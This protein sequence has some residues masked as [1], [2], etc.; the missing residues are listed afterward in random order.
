MKST[1]ATS[2]HGQAER[3]RRMAKGRISRGHS[4]GGSSRRPRMA[5]ASRRIPASMSGAP[6]KTLSM[7]GIARCQ[8]SLSHFPSEMGLPAGSV[9]LASWTCPTTIRTSPA[10]AVGQRRMRQMDLWEYLVV[11]TELDGKPMTVSFPNATPTGGNNY[12]MPDR[13]QNLPILSC[14]GDKTAGPLLHPAGPLG[15][16]GERPPL[17]CSERP[18]GRVCSIVCPRQPGC[19]P[20][21]SAG[22]PPAARGGGFR[23]SRSDH[24]GLFQ[25][26]TVRISPGKGRAGH[27]PGLLE[28][29]QKV[30]RRAGKERVNKNGPIILSGRG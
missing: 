17:G 12:I 4:S 23:G 15:P 26:S 20:I 25:K 19:A 16:E 27:T 7:L 2:T 9:W 1:L 18:L 10:S 13:G 11:V 30:H 8:L 6:R 3:I 24:I 29:S 21:R 22:S 28:E 5:I 14:I